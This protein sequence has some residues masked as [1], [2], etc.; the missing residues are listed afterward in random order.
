MTADVDALGAE[1]APTSGR[2]SPRASTGAGAALRARAPTPPAF[3]PDSIAVR[4]LEVRMV[5]G[6]DAWGRAVPQPVRLDAVV[7]TD[8]SQAGTTDHLPYSL[9]Y[10]ELYRALEWHAAAHSYCGVGALAEDVARVCTDEC[11]APWVEVCVHLPRALLEAREV[12]VRVVRARDGLAPGVD[13]RAHDRFLVCGMELYAVLGV[14]PWE[15]EDAQRLVV[16]LEVW[17]SAGAAFAVP[18]AYQALVRSVS[19]YV[20]ASSFQTVESL[21]TG[22]AHVA[23]TKHGVGCIGVRVEKPSAIM[24]AESAG[25][26]VGP[27]V[28]SAALALGSNLGDRLAHIDTAV[29]L[30]DAHP[31]VQIVDTSFLYETTPMYYLDQPKFV[32]GACRVLT[33]LSPHELLTCTQAVETQ[34]GRQ[35]EG[36]PRHGPRVVDVDILLYDGAEVRDGEHLVVPHPRIAERGFVLQPLRDILP[37]YVHPALGRT[38]EQLLHTLEQ[39]PV[40]ARG[41]LARVL[42]LASTL[43]RWGDRTLV[44]GILNATPDSFSDGGRHLRVQDAVHAA[45]AMVRA[46]ADVLDVGGQSTAPRAPE[47]AAAE[48]AARVVPLIAA[49]RR[50]P[51]TACTPISVDTYRA[52]VAAAALDAGATIVNDVSGGMRDAAMLPLVA[53]RGCPYV[54][55]HSRGDASSMDRLA[56]YDGN[57]ADVVAQELSVRVDA[58]LRV[59]V[60]R[61]N[62]ILDPGIG[63]AKA[64]RGNVEVLRGL[65]RIVG[66]CV[67]MVRVHDVGAAVEMVRVADAIA[68]DGDE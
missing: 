50:H 57:T 33:T 27:P 17:R 49:L 3:L 68:R 62:L 21:V 53:A 63:F 14:N 24:Y 59:G 41:E 28:H 67:D 60:R 32:N 64:A 6:L 13:L 23:V 54:L 29:R 56:T 26:Q 19:E 66:G 34:V 47:C 9:N 4:G 10:G 18:A 15:R 48:E 2:A 25:V 11:R 7:R 43:W 42:P 58:A 22:I 16:R 8:V 40:Y 35:K 45:C 46:G 65:S 31:A 20:R 51:D 44:M 39:Q 38:V 36:V 12:C 61:W 37:H 52:A 55:M 5:A 30:L 1:R